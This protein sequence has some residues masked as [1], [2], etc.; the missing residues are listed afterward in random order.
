MRDVVVRMNTTSSAAW[1]CASLTFG[2]SRAIVWTHQTP[3]AVL[4]QLGC[5]CGCMAIET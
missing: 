1:S 3:A 4:D 5:S 2:L